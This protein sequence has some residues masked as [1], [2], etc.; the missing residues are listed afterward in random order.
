MKNNKTRLWRFAL[1]NI[2]NVYI[3]VV[4]HDV[5]S[6]QEKKDVRYMWPAKLRKSTYHVSAI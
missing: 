4:N 6:S 1:S 5:S 3:G 2:K